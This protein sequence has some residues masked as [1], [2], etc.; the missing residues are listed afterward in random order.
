MTS[1]ALSTNQKYSNK[2]LNSGMGNEQSEFQKHRI[3]VVKHGLAA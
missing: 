2:D 3:V 1:G